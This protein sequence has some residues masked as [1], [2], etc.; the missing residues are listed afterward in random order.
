MNKYQKNKAALDDLIENEHHEWVIT[1]AFYSAM[2]C[3]EEYLFPITL[4]EYNGSEDKHFNK[5]ADYLKSYTTINKCNKHA[6]TKDLLAEYFEEISIAYNAL[7]DEAYS[8]RY[9]YN[10]IKYIEQKKNLS[11]QYLEQIEDYCLNFR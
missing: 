8:A 11:L 2:A 5:Y 1:V 10:Q 7:Y 4:E 9:S 3:V 6:A